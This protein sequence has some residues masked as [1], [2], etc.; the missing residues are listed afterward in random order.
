MMTAFTKTNLEFD[1]MYLMYVTPGSDTR[2]FVARFKRG[3]SGTFVTFLKKNFTVEEYFA[4][5][6][7]GEAPLEIAESKGYL[8]P[9]IKKW[10]KAGGYPV[11]VEGFK[12]MVADNVARKYK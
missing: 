9:H 3:A 7:A 8:L 1:G 4:R 5:R 11:T 2:T 12:M 6:E 10:L